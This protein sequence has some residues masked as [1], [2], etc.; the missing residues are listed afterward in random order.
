[1]RSPVHQLLAQGAELSHPQTQKTCCNLLKLEHALW[2][3]V[4][5]EGIEPTN[6]LAERCL[7]RAVLW[8][9]WC[10][11]TQS[12]NSALFVAR[13]LTTVTTLRLQQRDVLDFLTDACAALN[14]QQ[15]PPS[16]LPIPQ[17][18]ERLQKLL[19]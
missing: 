9:R 16:L 2:T 5:V 19:D 18:S 17:P 12:T 1:M 6:N 4:A 14:R 13:I 8:R 15:K 11:G 3:F 7:R 10:F